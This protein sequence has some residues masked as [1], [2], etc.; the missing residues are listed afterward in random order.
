MNS[1][2]RT[3]STKTERAWARLARVLVVRRVWHWF[4]VLLW[5]VR[6]PHLRCWPTPWPA[7]KTVSEYQ[8]Q[9]GRPEVAS[10]LF[11]EL[12]QLRN[13]MGFQLAFLGVDRVMEAIRISRKPGQL[14]EA[15]KQA[16]ADRS[17][18]LD[19]ANPRAS[20]QTLGIGPRGGLPKTKAEIQVIL[21]HMELST[22]GTLEQLRTRAR[23][24]LNELFAYRAE[25]SA[26]PMGQS[27]RPSVFGAET[28]PTG[29]G[30]ASGSSP[31]SA[32]PAAPTTETG[33]CQDRA[34]AILSEMRQNPELSRHM[35]NSLPLSETDY[36]NIGVDELMGIPEQ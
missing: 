8:K 12:I 4:G 32:S 35:L 23:D 10:T 6:R 26:R 20:L 1:E 9:P 30:A 3:E 28:T 16:V 14:M 36:F 34:A 25:R 27:D 33:N 24:G 15:R 17:G 2:S 19:L 22:E 7:S 11:L 31:A 29:P 18:K 13:K 21:Q 5:L